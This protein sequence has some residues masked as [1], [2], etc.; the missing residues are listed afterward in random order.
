MRI[1]G[2]G[3]GRLPTTATN[4]LKPGT[5]VELAAASSAF[6]GDTFVAGNIDS[7]NFARVVPKGRQSVNTGNSYFFRHTITYNARTGDIY[8]SDPP[9]KRIE[10]D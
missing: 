7:R 8:L 4:Q 3:F 9:R 1:K 6:I 5:R 2:D 10:N